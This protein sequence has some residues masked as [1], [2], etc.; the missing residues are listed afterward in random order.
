MQAVSFLFVRFD[1]MA[2]LDPA[3]ITRSLIRQVLDH[4]PM[5]E[6]LLNH[7]NVCDRGLF[8]TDA[9][10]TLWSYSLKPFETFFVV[11]DGLDEC[12]VSERAELLSAIAKLFDTCESTAK[13]KLL[14]SSR[15]SVTEQADRLRVPSFRL[16]ISSSI[17]H[18]LSTYTNDIVRQK[19]ST[20]ELITQ[21]EELIS[22]ILKTISIGGEG[23]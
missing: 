10:I 2:S 4:S 6:G 15:E 18:D 9:L 11:L 1:D 12:P 22:E 7:L 17:R 13:L 20:R 23:M 5:T 16:D 14:L 19:I 3:Q 21:D 8:D